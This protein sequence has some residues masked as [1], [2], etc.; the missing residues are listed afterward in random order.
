MKIIKTSELIKDDPVEVQATD[1]IERKGVGV[2]VNIYSSAI[3][4][5][6]LNDSGSRG[7]SSWGYVIQGIS[8]T[9]ESEWT[10]YG[11][12]PKSNMMEA[13][14]FSALKG[15]EEVRFPANVT[16]STNSVI[17][18]KQLSDPEKYLDEYD[19][20][21]QAETHSAKDYQRLCELRIFSK[22][23]DAV[24]NNSK[25][26]SLDVKW[27]PLSINEQVS[28]KATSMMGRA[29]AQAKMGIPK[30]VRNLLWN[31]KHLRG[32]R[33]RYPRHLN[34]CKTNFSIAPSLMND[35]VSYLKHKPGF[36]EESELNHFLPEPVAKR[37]M[38]EWGKEL[39]RRGDPE[40]SVS[41]T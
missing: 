24:R 17:L 22:L 18:T 9:R 12:M 34:Q 8:T 13:Y 5:G 7:L 30:G 23:M 15:L 3:S 26:L 33:I 29:H 25:I 4:K 28:P 1:V 6:F 16:L 32:D 19:K 39:D 31:V 14:T 38:T 21:S 10:R 35:V 36:L 41:R 37:I 11:S 2:E 20:L 40:L 27:T